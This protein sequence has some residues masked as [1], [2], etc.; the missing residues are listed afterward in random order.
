MLQ[1]PYMSPRGFTLVEL[2]VS[3]TIFTAVATIAVGALV[4]L[5]NASR[6]SRAMRIIMDNA[7][8]AVDSMSRTLRMGVRINCGCN[9][10][11]DA[12]GNNC[13]FT[14]YG[15]S[16]GVANQCISFYGPT[17]QSASM[18]KVQYRFGSTTN[19]VDRSINGGAWEQMTAPEVQV[20]GMNFFV[21]G[22]QVDQLQ[23]IVTMIMRGVAHASRKSTPF[24]IEAS[25][26]PRTPNSSLVAT[27]S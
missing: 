4:T 11:N 1:Y 16:A 3:V 23:P 24:S 26:S 27:S 17:G 14:N 10:A 12:T 9:T 20:T 21:N 18:S 13:Y 7:N 22:S 2:I 19:S 5:D 25:V 6:E 15:Q 8:S